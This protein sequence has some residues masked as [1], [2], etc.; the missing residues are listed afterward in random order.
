MTPS[1]Q[2]WEAFARTDAEFYISTAAHEREGVASSARFF[3]SGRRDAEL[4]LDQT[5]PW[6]ERR[7]AAVDFGAGVGRVA[8]TIARDFGEVVAVDSSPTMLAR[9]REHCDRGCVS[10]VRTVL[11]GD[12]WHEHV[13]ADLLYSTHVF[14]HI[15]DEDAIRS[16]LERARDC[17]DVT[18][19]AYLHFD[20]RPRSL[21]YE[22]RNRV[23]DP[24]LP[25]LWRRDIRRIRR[26]RVRL[27]EL[28][29]DADL[30]IVREVSPDSADQA[31]VVVPRSQ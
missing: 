28:L 7:R 22:V 21:L 11:A 31:F 20:T 29:A 13:T 12:R 27:I 4:I 6:L 26:S 15:A 10:N 17:L 16:A 2:A 9:L 3:S 24:L 1:E 23:P 18:G 25:P 8:L 5:A 19:V 30:R 14:Q